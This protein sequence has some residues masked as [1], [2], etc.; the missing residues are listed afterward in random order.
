MAVATYTYESLPP[1]EQRALPDAQHLIYAI[2][3]DDGDDQARRP[4]SG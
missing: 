1:E 3:A 2:T 4:Q